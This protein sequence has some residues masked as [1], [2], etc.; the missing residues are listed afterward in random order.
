MKKMISIICDDRSSN[1]WKL[2]FSFSFYGC[3]DDPIPHSYGL[4]NN[5]WAHIDTI[6]ADIDA[7]IGRIGC[8]ATSNT[9]SPLAPYN[10]LT[11][12]PDPAFSQIYRACC[13]IEAAT[14][15]CASP[16]NATWKDATFF[17]R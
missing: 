10:T 6:P 8:Q 5:T 11:R 17:N 4:L 14:M 13:L 15:N 1:A 9:S 12:D 2:R 3:I 7:M 16:L